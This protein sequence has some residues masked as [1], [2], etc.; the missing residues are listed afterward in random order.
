MDVVA[1]R[2]LNYLYIYL[3]VIWLVI[4][5]VLL[6][7]NKRYIALIAGF[8]GGMI[9]FAVDYGIFYLLLGTR[10]VTGADPFWF[11]LWLSM[12]Y[13]VTNMAWI[14]L[15]LDRDRRAVEWSAL[16][17]GAWVAVGL[18]S[19][20]FGANFAG[21]SIRRGTSS[22]HGIM[23]LILFAGY[24][25]LIVK[26]IRSAGKPGVNLLWLMA[27]GIGVQ[28]SW[29]AVL[30]LTNIRPPGFQALIIDSLIETNLG[31]PYVYLMHKAISARV[32]EDLSSRSSI[33]GKEQD[34]LM[35]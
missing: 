13:G 31:M 23:A 28:F 15:L 25:Y 19:Q 17:I 8:I 7:M 32:N 30:L 27:I 10:V 21:I 29:E 24:A 6:L 1:A 14:W 22:Y 12:S 34:I 18:L 35:A 11:L 3:D 20:N 26:N 33:F 2:T 16:I 5:A 4:F 9:Y